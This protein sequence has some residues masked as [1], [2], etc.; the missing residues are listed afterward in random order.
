[1][2]P[3]S[4]L[5]VLQVEAMQ[6]DLALRYLAACR[7]AAAAIDSSGVVLL[8]PMTASMPKRSGKYRAQLLVHALNKRLLQQYVQQF[9]PLLATVAGA[10]KVRWALDVDPLEI[11]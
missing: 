4:S 1:M 7:E 5:A 11:L 9:K 2:P 6:L 10:R 3:Y 8:G